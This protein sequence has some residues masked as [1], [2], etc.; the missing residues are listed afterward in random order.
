MVAGGRGWA[1]VGAGAVPRQL[2]S[3][4]FAVALSGTLS[5]GYLTYLELFEIEAICVW[6]V[7]SAGIVTA[8]A[9]LYVPDLRVAA[10]SGPRPTV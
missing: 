1:R 9:V 5:S 3:V 2:A 6:C 4:T 7:A 8:I 10:G